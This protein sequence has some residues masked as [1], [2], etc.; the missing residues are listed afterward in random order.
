M[1]QM[2]VYHCLGHFHLFCRMFVG[3]VGGG[4]GW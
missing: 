3:V 1:A 4:K 2:T